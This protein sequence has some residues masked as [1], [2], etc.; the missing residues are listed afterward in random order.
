MLL[1]LPFHH[2]MIY[3][4]SAIFKMTLNA[5]FVCSK[6]ALVICMCKQ[7]VCVC[8]FASYLAVELLSKPDNTSVF[9]H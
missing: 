2:L 6:F 7:S 4:P 9:V 3:I 5:I 8:V 1:L